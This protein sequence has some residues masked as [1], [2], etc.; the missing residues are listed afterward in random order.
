MHCEMKDSR[1]Q[2]LLADHERDVGAAT[3]LCEALA[4]ANFVAELISSA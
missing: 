3:A 2:S 1:P 4:S